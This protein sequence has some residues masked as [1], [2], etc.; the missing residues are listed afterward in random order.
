VSNSAGT[1]LCNQSFFV[2]LHHT[3]DRGIPVGF[4]HLPATLEEASRKVP[5]EPGLPLATLVEGV[6][7]ALEAIVAATSTTSAATPDTR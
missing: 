7:A 2:A 1:Y 3:A 5:P 6:E 4:V